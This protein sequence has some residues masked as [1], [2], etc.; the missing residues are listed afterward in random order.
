MAGM[1]RLCLILTAIAL[2]PNVAHV[3]TL[4]DNPAPSGS[5]DWNRVG[6]LVHDQPMV[7]EADGGR[8][9]HCLFTGTSGTT[10]FCD[11]Q[12]WRDGREYHVD[13]ADIEQVRLDQGHRNA[14]IVIWGVAAAG[15]VWGAVDP[16]FLAPNAPPLAKGVVGG[17][18]GGMAGIFLS[19]PAALLIPGRLV[20]R[21]P[22]PDHPALPAQATAQ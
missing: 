18:A 21:R 20:Y 22:K 14:K 2:L 12:V 6:E 4:P 19:L 9:L 8:T 15:F 3:Q 13:R 17:L 1:K 5:A 10:L 11:P 16:H 7:V